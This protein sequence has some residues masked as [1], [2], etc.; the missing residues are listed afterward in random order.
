MSDK[1]NDMPISILPFKSELYERSLNTQLS[2]NFDTILN[3]F[4]GAFRQ[5]MGSQY[6][7][8][9]LVPHWRNA[10]DNRQYAAAIMMDLS[11]EFDCLPHGLLLGK[12]RSCGLSVN[13]CGNV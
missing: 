6:T 10:L 8:L 1:Q 3:P 7:L 13:A 12:P 5:G 2:I 4:I 11:E 9:G